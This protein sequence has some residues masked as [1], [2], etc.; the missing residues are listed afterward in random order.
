M[1]VMARFQKI[2]DSIRE[3]IMMKNKKNKRT[4]ILEESTLKKIISMQSALQ[5][6]KRE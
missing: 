3:K 6:E 4:K 2:E 1:N 5:C